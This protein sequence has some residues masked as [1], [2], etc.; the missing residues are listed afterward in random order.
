MDWVTRLVP[1][2]KENFNACL[3]VVYRYSKNFIFLPF[4]KEDTAMYT[5]LIV[6][7]T[8][9]SHQNFGLTFMI[10]MEQNLH[11]LKPTTHKQM[12]WLKGQSKQLRKKSKYSVNMAWNTQTIRATPMTGLHSYQKFGWLTIPA[13]TPPQE[14]NPH[15]WKRDVI[16]YF[17]SIS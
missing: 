1:G 3:A 14:D 6:I 4:H 15:W 17:L 9:N 10:C 12:V 16:P 5:E 11:F 2:G 8:K 7:E 13:Y